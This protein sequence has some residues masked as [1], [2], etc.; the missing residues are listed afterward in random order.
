[1]FGLKS[2]LQSLA[3]LSSRMEN[4]NMM[5]AVVASC[6][7]VAA[8]DGNISDQEL[9]TTRLILESNDR[10][11]HFGPQIS[12]TVTKFGD[13][14]K[15]TFQLGELK[16]LREIGDIKSNPRD[17]EEVLVTAISIASADGKIEESEKRMIQKIAREL[18]LNASQYI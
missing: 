18:G 14:I 9:A 5:E 10:L 1:M 8:A 4:K 11:K 12:Q 7:L 16:L 17:A 6:I 3:G 15:G 13:M 2:K